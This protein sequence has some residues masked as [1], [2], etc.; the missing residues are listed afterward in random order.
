MAVIG[1]ERQAGVGPA[2]G[3]ASRAL[4]R[5]GPDDAEHVDLAIEVVALDK[6]SRQ[7]RCGARCAGGRSGRAE[8]CASAIAST[9]L[10]AFEPYEPDLQNVRPLCK[11]STAAR[12]WRMSASFET[13]R[14]SPSSGIGGSS[15]WIARY[16]P[17]AAATGTTARKKYAR[18]SRRAAASISLYAS[19]AAWKPAAV[20]A[21]TIRP[22]IPDGRS[23][24][25]GARR[26]VHR[27]EARRRALARRHVVQR[28]GA[29]PPQQVQLERDKVGA[30][31]GERA[32]AVRPFLRELGARPVE[33]RH[34]VVRDARD[35]ARAEVA[36][37]LAPVCDVAVAVGAGALDRLVHRDRLD[38]REREARRLDE[39]DPLADR[40]D[41]VADRNLVQ[42]GDD[43]GRAGLAHVSER[44]RVVRA[45]P[46]PGLLHLE[47][48]HH[49]R[50]RP[51]VP[52]E[53]C[54]RGRVL[55]ALGDSIATSDG[56]LS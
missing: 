4:A 46:T 7:H 13:T 40:L 5:K 55:G 33:H 16:T 37:R 50:R 15:G 56:D 1:P 19:S 24:E 43:A 23:L 53:R 29:R 26:L 51:D 21:S 14:G 39:R 20:Y 38:H 25:R 10:A 27:C 6:Q 31:E 9:L 12:T 34:E 28:F 17:A 44:H 54:V 3:D 11:S 52:S 8:A 42:R 30:V 48:G 49:G 22:G 32:R 41:H 47:G 35:A 45:V 2:F 36:H 18:F